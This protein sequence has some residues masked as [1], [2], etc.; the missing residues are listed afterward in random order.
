[1]IT[2]A[3]L[4]LDSPRVAAAAGSG[5]RDRAIS[6]F[7]KSYVAEALARHG[8]NVTHTAKEL[9]VHRTTLQRMMKKLA[10]AGE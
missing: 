9:G 1:V 7:E 6:E 5:G 10:I 8:G 3:D 4:P 2:A